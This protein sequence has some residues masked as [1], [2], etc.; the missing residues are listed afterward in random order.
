MTSSPYT[1]RRW[2]RLREQILI[3]DGHRCQIRGPRCR[4][5]ATQVDHILAVAD[6]GSMFDPSNLRAA[7]SWCNTWRAQKQ[8]SR[9]GWKRGGTYITLVMGPPGSCRELAKVIA[10]RSGPGDLVIDYR[11]LAAA[12]GDRPEEVK[13]VRGSLLTKLRRGE[14]EAARAWITS[15]NP[16][17]ESLF[18][19]HE[20]ILVDPGPEQALSG[21]D[22]ALSY[23]VH[24][25]YAIRGGTATAG[26]RQW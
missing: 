8:K 25:W 6:G 11:A 9:D 7:C 12:M 26:V 4:G 1:S 18:P 23:L 19:H 10:E 22:P 21:I 2:A 15:T 3:R 13:K 17:A 20:V 24:E 5:R 16:R 14:V